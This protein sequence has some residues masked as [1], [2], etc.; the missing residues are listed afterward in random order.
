MTDLAFAAPQFAYAL[1]VVLGITALLIYAELRSNSLLDRFVAKTMQAR[2]VERPGDWRRGLR[3]AL[4][5]L[6]MTAIVVA[7]M[8]P[9]WGFE[10]IESPQVGAEIMVALDVSRS[11][12]AEDVAPN[13]LERAKA[14]LRDLLPYLAGD[15]VGLIAFAGR[16]SVLCPLTP[17]FG[18][19]RVVL[20]NVDVGSV[21]RGGTR[22][23]EPIRKATRGFGT[24]GDLSRVL[25]LFTD[26]EDHDS[27]PLDAARQAAERGVR[28]IVIGFGDE[29]GS[30][31]YVSDPQ[32]GARTRV[33]D[34][35]G[36]PVISRLDGDLLREIALETDGAYVPAGTGL[37]DLKSIFEAHIRPLMRATGESRGR[38]V[39]KDG[40][41]W[42]LLVALLALLASTFGGVSRRSLAP[43]LLLGLGLAAAPE[44]WAQVPSP[45]PPASPAPEIPGEDAPD[46]NPALNRI[47]VP[48]DARDAY[49]VGIGALNTG[50]LEEAERL[51]EAA[52]QASG[53]DGEARYR[54]TYNLGWVEIVRADATMESAPPEA[55]THL[56]RSADWFREA[57]ALRPGDAAPRRNLEIVLQRAL[58]L[59]DS[60]AQGPEGDLASRLDTLIEEQRAAAASIRQ[61]S[62]AVSADPQA[63]LGENSRPLFKATALAERQTLANASALGHLAGDEL[64]GLRNSGDQELTPEQRMRALQLES[65]LAY[66]HQA[67]ERIGQARSQL[68]RKQAVR[69]HRRASSGLSML[70]RAREQLQNPV[71]ILDGLMGDTVR[72]ASETRTL[73]TA[74]TG[75]LAPG[76]GS[77][78]VPAW[79][80][81]EY[82]ADDQDEIAERGAEL[83]AK[84]TAG[85][86]QEGPGLEPEQQRLLEQ[87]RAAQPHLG[88]ATE[89][90]VAGSFALREQQLVEA[91][92]AQARALAALAEAREQFLDLK[93]LIEVAHADE[94]R[95]ASVFDEAEANPE[96][97]LG[98][99][100]PSL[101]RLQQRNLDRAQRMGSMVDAM[102][103]QLANSPPE[104]AEGAEAEAKRLE[105]AEGILALS[106]SSMRSA[107]ESLGRLSQGHEAV[108]PAKASVA[109]TLAGLDALRRLFFT[110]VEHLKDVVRQQIE[111]GD[112]TEAAPDL[113]TLERGPGAQRMAVHQ[114]GLAEYT[115]SLATALH[116]QSFADPADAAGSG[117]GPDPAQ[118]EEMAEKFTR[119]SEL[120]ILASEDMFGAAEGIAEIPGDPETDEEEPT[121]E[122]PTG[123][124]EDSEGE[125]EPPL[126]ERSEVRTLQDAAAQRILEALAILEPPDP[127]PQ[128]GDQG[129]NQ[130]QQ[131][132]EPQPGEDE[133]EP[134]PG[135]DE[136]DPNQL[137]Q[138]V[139]D[140]EA[141]RHRRNRDKNSSGY[142]PVDKDW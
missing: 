105:L 13:R 28:V 103:E 115:E 64:D 45:A 31:I 137:L 104:E 73:A 65:L 59:A 63:H 71:Q 136:S 34:S 92:N 101:Q 122:E 68:R 93:G 48:E 116:E 72:L 82:L 91:G 69:A 114:D 25:L 139:R 53:A 58:I 120:V 113:A 76:E 2:L 121:E 98:E 29:N 111:L 39:Q 50:D 47:E 61:L 4:L 85:L 18:F 42:A 130:P 36:R 19:L 41:Q 126:L 108:A 107:L 46:P 124:E 96:L 35:S 24:S 75:L 49:N 123:E 142:E 3:I 16:A 20:D 38:T 57:I 125:A 37:L 14:E 81:S 132:P 129:E 131:E 117:A 99:Y 66:L 88:D 7:A 22:L 30:E 56:E 95:I 141:E 86:E 40:F 21:S 135:E 97:E 89:E 106:E 133:G 140:R 9:Q 62:E 6:S 11:M 52:R 127:D 102:A 55:L 134:E 138:S 27:F 128:D 112:E 60:L 109:T 119:A 80:D 79:L 54:A 1:W 10:F 90:L 33:T 94:K 100:A 32:T 12:L 26:G 77:S 51:L 118:A 44:S 67:R 8:R 17:D 15:Q 110:V 5:C 23:E 43:L 83:D 74:S 84:L 70:K 78:P 87:L